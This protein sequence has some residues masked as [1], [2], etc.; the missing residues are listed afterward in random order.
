[1]P[2]K[3]KIYIPSDEEFTHI[4]QES[5]SYSEV[6]RKLDLQT[7]GG[8]STNILKRRIDELNLS[9]DHFQAQTEAARYSRTIP[10]KEI[11]VENSTYSNISRLKIRIVKEGLLKY[12]C[13]ECGNIGEWNNL[14]LTLQLDHINGVSN[15]HRIE[16]LRF[17]CPNCHAQTENYAGKNKSI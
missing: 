10:L 13:S 5:I 9:I 16:N 11:L 4:I 14:P 3:S 15:D 17:L 7:C 2:K 8:N 12:E 6:L 1:M